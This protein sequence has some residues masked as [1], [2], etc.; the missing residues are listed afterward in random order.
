VVA[1]ILAVPAITTSKRE[2]AAD[3]RR[4]LRE[5][6]AAERRRLEAEQR[7]R[8]GRV[9]TTAPVPALEAAISADAS[10]RVAAGEFETPVKRTDCEL[11]DESPRRMLFYCTAVTSDIPKSASSRGA[12]VGYP[13]RAR[14]EPRDGRYAFCKTSGVPGEGSLGSGVSVPL[15]RACGGG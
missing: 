8:R 6:R 13:Y 11:L 1:A 4:E 12:L 14:V 9:R 2:R 15:P 3:E 5:S 10:E 7:P